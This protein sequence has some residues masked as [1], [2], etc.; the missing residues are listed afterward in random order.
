MLD[1]TAIP[2]TAA[3]VRRHPAAG[4]L[5]AGRHINLR[6]GIREMSVGGARLLV[7][8]TIAAPDSFQLELADDGVAVAC[9]VVWRRGKE[10]GVRFLVPIATYAAVSMPAA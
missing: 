4:V 2:D 10:L 9:A 6:C 8:S 1:S 7:E 3:I 5:R